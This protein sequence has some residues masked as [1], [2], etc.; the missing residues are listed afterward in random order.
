MRK[1]SL[2]FFPLLIAATVAVLAFLFVRLAPGAAID[3]PPVVLA[4]PTSTEPGSSGG[5][6]GS[7]GKAVEVTTETVQAVI[8]ALSGAESY[9][10]T[11]TA[12]TFWSGGSSVREYQVWAHGGSVKIAESSEGRPTKYVLISEGELWIWYSDS[13]SVYHGAAGAL[14]ADRYQSLLSYEDILELDASDILDAGYGSY[15]GEG[16]VF[17]RYIQG[18][19]GYENLCFVSVETGLPVSWEIW[20]GDTL[21]Y[22][23]RSSAVEL[24]TPD[25]SVFDAP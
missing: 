1:R 24:S 11:V 20:D 19:L 14:D 10:R 16:C 6:E 3:T 5:A 4:T 25:D 22:S 2:F 13:S 21:I 15:S 7:D 12:E 17:V 18:E 9:S 8:S 23:M